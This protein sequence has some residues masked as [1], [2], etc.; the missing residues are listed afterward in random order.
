MNRLSVDNPIPHSDG[1]IFGQVAWSWYLR[2]AYGRADITCNWRGDA[3]LQVGDPVTVE[4]KYG[5]IDGVIIKQEIDY[6]G[7]LNMRT[8]VRQLDRVINSGGGN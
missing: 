8:T 6:D 1:D 4:G 2:S 7:A 5:P 3:S